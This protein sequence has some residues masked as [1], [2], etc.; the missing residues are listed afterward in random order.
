MI[1]ILSC[2]DCRSEYDLIYSGDEVVSET[3]CKCYRQSQKEKLDKALKQL[4]IKFGLKERKVLNAKNQSSS[5]K[6]S[7]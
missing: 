6:V 5:R 2:S 1:E 3:R 4:A 7:R